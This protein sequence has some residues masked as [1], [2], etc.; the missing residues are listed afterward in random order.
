MM[1]MQISLAV[2]NMFWY[3]LAGLPVERSAAYH[4][5]HGYL[6]T[7]VYVA[8][9]ICFAIG[10]LTYRHFTS[11]FCFCDVNPLAGL[12]GLVFQ[13]LITATSLPIVRRKNWEY[14]YL[15]GHL[16]LL[17]P[18]LWAQLFNNRLAAFPWFVAGAAQWG[19]SDMSLRFFMKV[20]QSTKVLSVTHKGGVTTLRCTKQ[21]GGAA[22]TLG[23]LTWRWEPGSYVWLAVR[24]ENANPLKGK[25]PPPFSKD[26]ACY[27]PITIASPPIDA[28]GNPAKDFTMHI[29]SF[30]PGTWSEALLKKA[31]LNE[32]PDAWKV[33]VGG[34]NGRLSINPMDCDKVVLCG[35]GVGCT[36]FLALATDLHYRAATGGKDTPAVPNVA[37]IHAE[38]QLASFDVYQKELEALQKAGTVDVKLFC[39][40]TAPG[41]LVEGA[42]GLVAS[43]GAKVSQGRPDFPKLLAAAGNASDVKV[44]VSGSKQVVGVYACGPRPMMAAVREAVQAA[45]GPEVTYYLHEETYEL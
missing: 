45:S 41:E 35:G 8:I 1:P 3:L 15:M 26:W 9:W 44:K 19:M 24:M 28:A 13:L 27:H 20:L 42:G 17:F 4:A 37:Y 21:H 12:I 32:A 39:T 16:Q 23:I 10:G 29:K 11:P 31:Q 33:W 34:P 7:L 25:A 40:G 30:G 5:W 22:K 38:R 43:C 6:M 14:F 2:K 36:P 18:L